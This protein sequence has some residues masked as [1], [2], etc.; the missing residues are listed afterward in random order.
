MVQPF[1][2]WTA[3]LPGISYESGLQGPMLNNNKISTKKDYVQKKIA[4]NNFVFWTLFLK[5]TM[6]AFFVESVCY[7]CIFI[8]KQTPVPAQRYGTSEPLL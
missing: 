6:T 5:G 7:F 1:E 2:I 8:T 4:K 3:D